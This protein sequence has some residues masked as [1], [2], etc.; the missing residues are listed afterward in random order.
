MDL[1]VRIGQPNRGREPRNSGTDDVDGLLHQ[2][3]A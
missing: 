1:E 3:R 2:I